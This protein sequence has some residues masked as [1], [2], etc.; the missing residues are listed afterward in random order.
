MEMLSKVCKLCGVEKPLTEFIAHKSGNH[1]YYYKCKPCNTEAGRKWKHANRPKRNK[2]VKQAQKRRNELSKQSAYKSH[3]LWSAEEVLT[4]QDK[5]KSDKELAQLLNRSI[6]S[7]AR[8]RK[9]EGI[10]K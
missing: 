9:R 5:T 3:T 4:I 2:N 6:F 7:I 10:H 1:V 8:K